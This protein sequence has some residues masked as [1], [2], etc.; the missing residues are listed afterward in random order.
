MKNKSISFAR[1]EARI[2]K[3]YYKPSL[4]IFRFFNAILG[5][6]ISGS[7]HVSHKFKK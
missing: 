1:E 2:Y 5:I 7:A 6:L 4:N 3:N